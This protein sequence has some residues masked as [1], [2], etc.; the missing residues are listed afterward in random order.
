MGVVV[1]G[2]LSAECHCSRMVTRRPVPCR[3]LSTTPFAG[4]TNLVSCSVAAT[5]SAIENGGY[6]EADVAKENLFRDELATPV[7]R[8]DAAG[9]VTPGDAPGLGVE[10]DEQF[11]RAHPPIEGPAYV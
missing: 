3:R 7:V 11:L 2:A 1:G 8:V 5:L 4:S 6:Y 9:C 10:V